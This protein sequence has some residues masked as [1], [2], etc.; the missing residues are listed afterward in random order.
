MLLTRT[1]RPREERRATADLQFTVWR[2]RLIVLRAKTQ[3]ACIKELFWVRLARLDEVNCE[4]KLGTVLD[5]V[6]Q[7]RQR[8]TSTVR[9]TLEV[10]YDLIL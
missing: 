1:T 6:G 3:E 5:T 8:W 2:P 4:N 9:R 7:G 10:L